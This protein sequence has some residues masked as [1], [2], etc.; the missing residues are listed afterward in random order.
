MPDDE[1]YDQ[2]EL[3]KIA[4]DA[5][6]EAPDHKNYQGLPMPG[7]DDLGDAIQAAWISAANAVADELSGPVA[8]D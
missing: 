4:Y 3:A 7:W 5:Y 6:G 8:S 2:T 1:L